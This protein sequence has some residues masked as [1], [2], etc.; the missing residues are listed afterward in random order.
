MWKLCLEPGVDFRDVLW[1]F[2]GAMQYDF[3]EVIRRF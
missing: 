3:A 2:R 1:G